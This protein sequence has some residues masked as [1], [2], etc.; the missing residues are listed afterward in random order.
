MTNKTTITYGTF[1][2]FHIGHLNLLKRIKKLGGF[3]IVGVST[4]DFNMTKGKKTIIPY[5]Q[6]AE[7]VS[8]L[9]YVD[10]VIPENNWEQKAEDIK[11]HNV[12]TFVIGMDWKGQFDFL[13]D[14][15]EV[16]YLERTK[17]VSSTMLK[18]TLKNLVAIPREELILAFDVLDRLKKEFS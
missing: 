12:D 3:S 11:K 9:K 5:E 13:S 4:D 15:C 16:V 14:Y 17:D 1:D 10:L 8:S 18:D 2:L 6:R 7:I